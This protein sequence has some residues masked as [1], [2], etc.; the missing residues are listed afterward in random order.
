MPY[1][2][3]LRGVLDEQY[4]TRMRENVTWSFAQAKRDGD[5]HWSG[6]SLHEKSGHRSCLLAGQV[7]T[8]GQ[9]SMSGVQEPSGQCIWS[10][11]HV[12]ASGHSEAFATHRPSEHMTT[13]LS[14]HVRDVG[15]VVVL[16]LQVPSGHRAAFV[17]AGQW[18]IGLH[19]YTLWTHAPVT[20]AWDRKICAV[21]RRMRC[22]CKEHAMQIISTR[23][24]NR[25]LIT[26]KEGGTRKS[27]DTSDPDSAA[28]IIRGWVEE[29]YRPSRAPATP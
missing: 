10:L 12:R 26:R 6:A 18:K 5:E 25:K 21:S 9:C 3:M 13:W 24:S 8:L 28:R 7:D 1:I 11:E 17:F 20:V 29:I 23:E 27:T 4:A 19:S 2:H 22:R 16:V 14:G 15:Q